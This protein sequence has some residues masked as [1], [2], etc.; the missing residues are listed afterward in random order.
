M[1]FS[2]VKILKGLCLTMVALSLSACGFHTQTIKP[3]VITMNDQDVPIVINAPVIKQPDVSTGIG[4][5]DHISYFTHQGFE[6]YRF[7]SL[8]SVNQLVRANMAHT[9]KLMEIPVAKLAPFHV[10]AKTTQLDISTMDSVKK[11]VT[12]K[13]VLTIDYR[14][15][16]HGNLL[17]RDQVTSI[18]QMSFKKEEKEGAAI[19]DLVEF[20]LNNNT[21]RMGKKLVQSCTF[22]LDQ[23]NCTKYRL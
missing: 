8:N 20:L 16:Q 22:Y 7:Y 9:F 15:S 10:S 3:K 12:L 14:L 11:P 23:I 21:S 6:F 4:V 17:W 18:A 13:G 2:Q 1:K 5:S 19:Q